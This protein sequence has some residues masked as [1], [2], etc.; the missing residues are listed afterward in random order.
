[1]RVN[2]TLDQKALNEQ[3]VDDK[4]LVSHIQGL[5][6]TVTNTKMLIRFKVFTTDIDKDKMQQL[7]ANPI[8]LDVSPDERR[9]AI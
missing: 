8:V 2:I 6:L 3:G 1:M 5:G 7:V 9:Q 4:E